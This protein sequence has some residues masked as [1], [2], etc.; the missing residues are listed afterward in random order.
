M[1]YLL[2]K[3]LYTAWPTYRNTLHYI[4]MPGGSGV[5]HRAINEGTQPSRVHFSLNPDG[6]MSIRLGAKVIMPCE[7]FSRLCKPCSIAYLTQH[8]RTRTELNGGSSG[9]YVEI[10]GKNRGPTKTPVS[11]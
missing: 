8:Q 1:A 7:R 2:D 4:K 9:R 3:L 6:G 11:E 5:G 10:F